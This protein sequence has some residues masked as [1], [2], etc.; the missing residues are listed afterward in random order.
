MRSTLKSDCFFGV[1]V[2]IKVFLVAFLYQECEVEIIDDA[3]S[4]AAPLDLHYSQ[5]SFTEIHGI[6]S[7]ILKKKC[8]ITVNEDEIQKVIDL[9]SEQVISLVLELTTGFPLFA[10]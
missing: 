2:L 5:S 10:K 7:E 4:I 6:H 8:A 1:N 9:W 3:Y